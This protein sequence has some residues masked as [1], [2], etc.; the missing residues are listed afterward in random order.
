[1]NIGT[2]VRRYL[3]LKANM[4]ASTERFLLGAVSDRRRKP[5]NWRNGKGNTKLPILE[6][7]NCVK[8][9]CM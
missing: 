2:S 3:R 8:I 4:M 9:M 5:P 6:L 1:M 7:K